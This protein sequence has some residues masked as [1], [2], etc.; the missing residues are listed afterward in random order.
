MKNNFPRSFYVP[1]TYA[2]VARNDSLGVEVYKDQ[3]PDSIVIMAFSGKRQKADFHLRFKT[4]EQATKHVANWMNNLK[5]HQEKVLERREKRKEGHTLKVGD[6]LQCMWGY[7]QTN[8][9]YYQVTALLGTTMVEIREV[10]Q[11]IRETEFMQGKTT[12][13]PDVFVGPA[14]KHRVGERN[15]IR[16]NSYSWAF[17]CSHEDVSHWTSYA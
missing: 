7:E 11:S 17:P 2:R 9:D 13:L 10:G 12:P 4:E 6:L 16:L 15:S 3:R 14:K 1:K 5:A 8:I